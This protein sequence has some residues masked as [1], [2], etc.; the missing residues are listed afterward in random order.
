MNYSIVL[1]GSELTTGRVLDTNS[2]YL[3]SQLVAQGH[4][5]NKILLCSDNSR[6]IKEAFACVKGSDLVFVTGGLGPTKDDMTRK[7]AAEYM[8]QELVYNPKIHDK[9]NK[10]LAARG[11]KAASNNRQQAYFPEESIIIPN[12]LGTADGFKINNSNGWWYFFPGVPV[13]MKSLFKTVAND[14]ASDEVTV[15]L[16]YLFT[17]ASESAID[18]ELETIMEGTVYSL[19]ASNGF[20]KFF[21]DFKEP[22]L[23]EAKKKLIVSKLQQ[24]VVSDRTNDPLQVLLDKAVSKKVKL[25]TAESCTGGK[26]GALL[27]ELAGSSQVFNGS[28]IAYQNF[29]KENILHVNREILATKG[30]VSRECVE[31][32]VLGASTILGSDVTLS[33]SGIAGPSG[34]SVDKPV[35]TVWFGLKVGNDIN[36]YKMEFRG[37]R[38]NVRQRATYY[39]IRLLLQAVDKI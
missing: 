31:A 24:Y 19:C 2:S 4:V 3:S 38:D 14:F 37:N 10:F 33:I 21:A 6:S 12:S 18:A 20:Y 28:I 35:G 22:A 39:G 1:I 9:L 15:S 27:S 36:S 7:I 13:E 16:E 25:G 23:M 17:G 30:A 34:G 26:V 11:I 5:A 32:M 29:I 8:Q